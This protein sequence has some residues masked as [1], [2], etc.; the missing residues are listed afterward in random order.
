MT[1]IAFFELSPCQT[2][3]GGGSPLPG[4]A[5]MLH[6]LHSLVLTRQAAEA[7][8]LWRRAI[9]LAAWHTPLGFPGR[10]NLDR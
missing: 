6:F 7:Y 9:T 2:W 1:V 4:P 3:G 8:F 5:A 10:L